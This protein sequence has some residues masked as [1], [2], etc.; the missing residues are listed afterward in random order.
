MDHGGGAKSRIVLIDVARGYA[1]F[2]VY[3]G[4]IVERMIHSDSPAA[5]HY[6]FIYSFHMV[7]F[8]LLAGFVANPSRTTRPLRVFIRH[9][10]VSRLLPYLFF[11]LIFSVLPFFLDGWLPVGDSTTWRVYFEAWLSALIGGFPPFAVP[12]WFLGC[13]VSVEILHYV[14]GRFLDSSMKLLIAAA[15]LYLGG[16]YLNREIPFFMKH[17]NVWLVHEAVV[18]YAFYLLGVWLRRKGFLIGQARFGK[19]GLWGFV[20]LGVLLTALTFD[21]N[22]SLFTLE[23]Y[24]A[25]VIVLSSHGHIFWFPF[26]ALAGIATLM[27]LAKSTERFGVVGWIGRNA[28]IVFCLN[29]VFYH[30]ANGPF[31]S[32]VAAEFPDTHLTV[33]LSGVF[34]T[35]VCLAMTVP[36]VLL[37]NK[38]LPQLTGNPKVDGPLLPKLI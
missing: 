1:L 28:L 8:F 25:V 33:L 22:K 38:Y 24:D 17:W 32:W 26:T 20:G 4:H 36:V 30:Y 2:L 23:A 16:Y 11:C 9:M 31:T 35:A 37:L 34:F 7:F 29:S 21:L 15:A 3:Y 18:V 5:M 12:M 10:A 13:L 6:K 19:A 14:L 27:L